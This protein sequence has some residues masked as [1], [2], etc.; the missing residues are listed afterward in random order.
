LYGVTANHQ[1]TRHYQRHCRAARAIAEE[2]FDAQK[3]ARAL[4]ADVA[5]A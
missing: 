4:L 5:G 3:I 1:K 2:H